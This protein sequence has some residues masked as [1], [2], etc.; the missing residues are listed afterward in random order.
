MQIGKVKIGRIDVLLATAVA[1]LLFVRSINIQ[2]PNIWQDFI[3]LSLSILYEATP[4]LLLGIIIS[5][6]VQFYVSSK[7]FLRL[8][9]K[10]GMLR[11]F[12]LSLLGV[13]LPVCE[14]GNVPLSRGLM[15]KGLKPADSLPFLFAAPIL[16]PITIAS[17]AVA[18]S[19]DSSIV[20]FRVIFALLIANIIGWIYSASKRKELI[21]DD[22]QA[23]CEDHKHDKTKKPKLSLE[24]MRDFASSAIE[25]VNRLL[26]ALIFGSIQAGVIQTVIPRELLTTVAGEPI[27]AILIMI[28]LAFVVSICASVDAFFALSLSGVFPKS[29]LVAFLVFGPMIDIKMLSL[30]KT[31]Y[32]THVL[33]GSTIIVFLGALL[34]GLVV[35][36]GF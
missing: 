5:V 19:F 9:P 14:C 1:A 32:R 24:A 10:K 3:T 30:M 35:Q 6:L 17:T 15:S 11:R 4:F 21:T 31:T 27:L 2:L 8:L 7:L 18:F 34:A 25:E 12:T 23:Y 20:V 26:P 13:F 36:Y 29:S 16:T 28:L 22:F 33:V